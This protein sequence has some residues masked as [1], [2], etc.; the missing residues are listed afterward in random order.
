[1]TTIE[2][3]EIMPIRINDMIACIFE[4]K[5]KYPQY[6]KMQEL[7]KLQKELSIAYRH[8]RIFTDNEHQEYYDKLL[9]K[10]NKMITGDAANE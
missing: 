7:E 3:K 5:E 8:S 4:F 6:D 10:A 2:E 1:M 9:D